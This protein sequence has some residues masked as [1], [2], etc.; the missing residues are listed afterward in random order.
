M[1]AARERKREK[2]T[3]VKLNCIQLGHSANQRKCTVKLIT[4]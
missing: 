4:L 3:V 2:K 1:P